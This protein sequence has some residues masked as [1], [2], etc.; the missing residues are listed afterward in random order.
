MTDI[1]N[2]IFNDTFNNTYLYYKNINICYTYINCKG[3]TQKLGNAKIV[4]LNQT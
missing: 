4:V 2:N 3:N 1:F